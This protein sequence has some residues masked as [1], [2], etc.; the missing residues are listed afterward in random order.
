MMLKTLLVASSL[1]FAAVVVRAQS[2][3]L[4]AAQRAFEDGR[5]EDSLTQLQAIER[6]AG[7][8]PRTESV[9]ALALSAW[10]RTKEAYLSVL[11]YQALT[12]RLDLTGNTAHEAMLALRD[13]LRR[14]LEG[15]RRAE[16]DKLERERLAEADKAVAAEEQ[17]AAAERQALVASRSQQLLVARGRSADP[18]AFD[19][20]LKEGL[21]K[22]ADALSSQLRSAAKTRGIE[23]VAS[24]NELFARQFNRDLAAQVVTLRPAPGN[25]RAPY[26]L[27]A[28]KYAGT[29][30]DYRLSD[31]SD[32]G[33]TLEETGTVQGFDLTK[34]EPQGFEV[35]R[36]DSDAPTLLRFRF[37]QPDLWLRGGA[38]YS[39][40]RPFPGYAPSSR[41]A[42]Q[43][44]LYLPAE[45]AA[46]VTRAFTDLI[47]LQKP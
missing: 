9:R 17:R 7:L 39:D 30:I 41:G 19:A 20:G 38:R 37:R 29:T 23:L 46:D 1:A 12:A 43:L 2:P 13:E 16:H 25:D 18:R 4:D 45:I 47:S 8:N 22:D 34:L 32:G 28:F 36:G 33:S 21:G 10:G 40:G 24:V 14:R 31:R 3:A 5:F 26:R 42:N 6:G 15:E 11:A 35:V 44:A 27:L